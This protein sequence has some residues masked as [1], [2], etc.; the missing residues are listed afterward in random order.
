MRRHGG[1]FVAL[2][3]LFLDLDQLVRR[4]EERGEG[5]ADVV[6]FGEFLVYPRGR[7]DEQTFLLVCVVDSPSTVFPCCLT[8]SS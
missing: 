8:N 7:M 5:V 4:T 3:G 1:G 6:D 2:L